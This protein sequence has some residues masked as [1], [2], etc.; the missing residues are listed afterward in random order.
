[1]GRAHVIVPG[2]FSGQVLVFVSRMQPLVVP[3]L[4]THKTAQ[5][6]NVVR[7]TALQINRDENRHQLGV[8]KK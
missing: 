3:A 2:P 8:T 7:R 5:N 6:R 1:M 4:V